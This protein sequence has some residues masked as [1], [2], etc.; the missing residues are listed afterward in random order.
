MSRDESQTREIADQYSIGQEVVVYY[1]PNDHKEAIL[2]PGCEGCERWPSIED[3][4]TGIFG[5][6]LGVGLFLWS[7]INILNRISIWINKKVAT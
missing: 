3:T 4:C 7:F 2:I 6:I 1:N 5:I